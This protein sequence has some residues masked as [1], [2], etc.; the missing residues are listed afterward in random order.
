M[1]PEKN[2]YVFG[3]VAR[4]LVAALRKLWTGAEVPQAVTA[5]IVPPVAVAESSS[6]APMVD[7]QTE[8]SQA[9]DL[10]VYKEKYDREAREREFDEYYSELM[11]I[12]KTTIKKFD[13]DKKIEDF[14]KNYP[15][16]SKMLDSLTSTLEVIPLRHEL[17]LKIDRLRNATDFSDYSKLQEAREK[18]LELF[19]SDCILAYDILII[20]YD[21]I[22]SHIPDNE[23]N[24]AFKKLSEDLKISLLSISE[25]VA[26]KL[27]I[28]LIGNLDLQKLSFDP[29]TQRVIGS[30][31][32]SVGDEVILT[33]R[34]AV[35]PSQ[36]IIKPIVS[37]A[38]GFL[39][40][41]AKMLFFISSRDE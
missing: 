41:R 36:T 28:K 23:Y 24:Q 35:T 29:T 25:I 15:Q 39:S 26:S 4:K 31:Q 1:N 38:Q 8:L 2:E 40:Y 5:D 22:V 10:P 9:T 11:N 14:K 12:W 33:Q 21:Y 6:V 16:Q 37:E 17:K 32:P 20:E 19:I 18:I 3:I 7:P 30:E 27:R 13:I 34:G